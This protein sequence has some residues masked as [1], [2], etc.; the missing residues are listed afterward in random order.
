MNIKQIILAGVL[1]VVMVPLLLSSTALAGDGVDCAVLPSDICA[2]ADNEDFSQSGVW[3]ILVW[4]INI[5][6]AGVG[7]VAVG[8]IAFAGFLYATARD[9]PSQTKKA[10]EMIRNTAIGLLV[11]IFMFA[12]LQYL[13]PGGVLNSSTSTGNQGA[14]PSQGGPMRVN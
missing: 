9:D 1:A 13:I 10:I 2:A 5:L 11:Y 4:T 6:S 7:I 8:A 12:I 14:P 3:M